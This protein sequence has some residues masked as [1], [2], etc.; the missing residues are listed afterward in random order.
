MAEAPESDG[1]SGCGDVITPAADA[2]AQIV[3]FLR[4]IHPQGP[5]CLTAIRPDHQG[6]PETRTY[7]PATVEICCSWLSERNGKYNLYWH[8]NPVMRPMNK[9]AQRTD[10][11]E[12][13]I[14]HVDVDPDA[15]KPLEEQQEAILARFGDGLPAGVPPPTIVIFSGGGYQA[16][17]KLLEPAPIDGDLERA[18]AAS[19]YNKKLEA[20][21]QAD[22]CHNVDRL[23]RLPFTVNLPDARKRAKGRRPTLTKLVVNEPSRTYP[24]SVFEGIRGS[25]GD[26]VKAAPD[27]IDVDLE[28]GVRR[29]EALDELGEWN[30]PERII[31]IIARGQCEQSG[32]KARKD[33][34][35]SAWLFDAICGLLRSGVPDSIIVGIITDPKWA[36]SVSVVE[37]KLAAETYALRQVARAKA[38][39]SMATA[40][41]D[42]A[43]LVNNPVV[44]ET[45]RSI[46]KL[47]LENDLKVF[48][49]EKRLV[50]VSVVERQQVQAGIVRHAGLVELA[51]VT[52][53][54]LADKASELGTFVVSTA[55]GLR[56]VAPNRDHMA[57]LL[58]I[59]DESRFPAIKGL[60]LTP[61]LWCNEPGY[62]EKSQLYLAFPE[63]LFPNAPFEPTKE[64]AVVALERLKSPLRSFPFV[65]AAARSVALS[66]LL[67]AVVRGELR[68]CPLHGF[69]A[70][71]A[72]TGKTKLALMAGTLALGVEPPSITFGEDADENQKQLSSLLMT[73]C[74]AI[75]LDNVE[76][77]LKG[78]FLNGI[79]TKDGFEARI[80]GLSK[81]VRLN[82]RALLMAT[83]NN[84]RCFGDMARRA[85]VCRMDAK[86]PNPED[87]QFD[88]DP[89]LEVRSQ[90]PQLVVDALTVLRAFLAA[91]SPARL[92]AYGSFEDWDLIRG[93]LV[94]LGEADPL[95]TKAAVAANNP[96]QEE[97]AELILALFSQFGIGRRFKISEIDGQNELEPAGLKA[98]IGRM[99]RSGRWH[100]GEAG[101]LLTAHKEVPYMGLTLVAKQNR[102]GINEWWLDGTPTQELEVEAERYR[103]ATTVPFS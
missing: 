57:A 22:N 85:V 61:T 90:R 3:Q 56:R 98:K 69:D 74:G 26:A 80:L 42:A 71:A 70:P 64:E 95:D 91:G 39:V 94:W 44:A 8:V 99:L 28:G 2:S 38:K 81:M 72:G 82:T 16:F 46:E 47:F 27:A 76:V 17:W 12:L 83:G 102:I 88:F 62:D 68:T 1:S 65:D 89:L 96:K 40:A 48:R 55:K 73:G 25:A 86:M 49:Q 32:S 31:E 100:K 50:R 84:L 75:L 101:Q 11:K 33:Q 43:I 34:S 53:V 63:G 30:V 41:G 13:A 10:I 36:I 45:R 58:E 5:W 54:W 77:P 59:T 15:S 24:L 18:E 23:M 67:S 35:R 21:F 97:R 51:P 93:A 29:I 4:S 37:K 66:A 52:G 78:A 6:A 19:H 14:L 20:A 7:G 79:I 60:S 103:V 87:R 92:P 9:K